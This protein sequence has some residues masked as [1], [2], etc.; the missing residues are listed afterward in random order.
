MKKRILKN[1]YIKHYMD[2][3]W[4]PLTY[5]TEYALWSRRLG[6]KRIRD[7]QEARLKLEA[8]EYAY[9]YQTGKLKNL[10]INKDAI[11]LEM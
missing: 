2:I 5:N 6:S 4:N 9:N 8:L 7:V 3:H 11:Y 10:V 1:P